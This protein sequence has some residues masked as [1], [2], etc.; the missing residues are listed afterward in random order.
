MATKRS[1]VEELAEKKLKEFKQSK[2][3]QLELFFLPTE[4]TIYSRTI[5]LYDAIP[6]YHYGK[7]FKRSEGKYLPALNRKFV[8]RNKEYRVF[9]SP[10]RI[11]EVDNEGEM[12]NEKDYYPGKREELIE[13]A[14]RKIAT[15]NKGIYLA[16]E[17]TNEVGVIFTLYQLQQELA[18]SGH[19]YSIV[20]L[21][22]GLLICSKATLELKSI[23]G[24]TILSDQL[25]STVG[26]TTQDDWK[27]S[28]RNSKAF[29]RFNPLVTQS[30]NDKTFRE[31]NYRVSMGYKYNVSRW[32]HKRMSHV[33]TQASSINK[34]QIKA[35]TIIRD[36]GA[37]TCERF[38]D[39]LK[40]IRRDL[41]EMIEKET[42]R[43]YEEEKIYESS[44]KN[45][46]TDVLF[47]LDPS[48]KFIKE[49]KK[50]NHHQK[51]IRKLEF[52]VNK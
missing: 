10:A 22:D 50:F 39:A 28:G 8:H 29:V 14:L 21:K 4:E 51:Q 26:L 12:I 2:P 44:R 46:I 18:D 40:Q 15:Q 42:L 38:T 7:I 5:E 16:D 6:K 32:L 1:I 30:L 35:S 27:G 17:K 9:V 3:Q 24:K 48:F 41:D 43:G 45:K 11:I 31:Y 52:P 34:Y 13:E 37:V 49:M 36:S 47:T 33:Y 20:Q 23:D 19:K 25:L